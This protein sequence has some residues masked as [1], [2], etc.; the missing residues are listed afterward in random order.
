M[1]EY[2]RTFLRVNLLSTLEHYVLK[3]HEHMFIGFHGACFDFNV[4]NYVS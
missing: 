3:I 4:H 2:L 1:T